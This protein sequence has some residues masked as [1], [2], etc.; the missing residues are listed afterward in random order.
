MYHIENVGYVINTLSNSM[1]HL[2]INSIRHGY[3]F[4]WP[5]HIIFKNKH[6]YHLL[7]MCLL[8]GISC[9]A[10]GANVICKKGLHM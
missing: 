2:Y 3:M 10:Y 8:D 5:N 4:A 9:Q 1:Y 7:F 6:G